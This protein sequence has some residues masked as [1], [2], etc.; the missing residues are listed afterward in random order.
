M[1]EPSQLPSSPAAADAPATP[2]LPKS[3]LEQMQELLASVTAD[4][5]ELQSSGARG[6]YP[7][8]TDTSGASAAPG[9]R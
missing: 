9:T 7:A 4:L 2:T 6:A 1:S 3:L 8:G 5:A